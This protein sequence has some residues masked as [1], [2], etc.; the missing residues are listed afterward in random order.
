MYSEIKIDQDRDVKRD[1]DR[2]RY[3]GMNIEAPLQCIASVRKMIGQG[4]MNALTCV[5][6]GVTQFHV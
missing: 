5:T 1:Q 6:P 4:T 2:L 3:S